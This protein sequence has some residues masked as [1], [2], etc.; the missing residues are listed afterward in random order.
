[1]GKTKLYSDA[2]D[3]V[4]F[5][6]NNK[7]KIIDLYVKEYKNIKQ[8]SKLYQCK[9]TTI[10]G[11]LKEWG[12]E[13]RKDANHRYNNL[14]QVDIDFLDNINT[15]QKAWLVGYILADGCVT[16]TGKI[17][18][19]CKD[20]DILP[21]IKNM[22]SSDVSIRKDSHNNFAM[23]ICSRKLTSRL[24]EMGITP[25][26]SYGFDFN[27]TLS[28]IPK[29]LLCHFV[30]GMFDGDGSIRYYNYEYAKG[31]QYHL[32]YTGIKEV[33]K[34]VD[35]FLSL[36]T[37]MIKEHNSEI[38]HTIRTAN[39]Q[40]IVNAY[41]ILYKNATIYSDRKFNTFQKVLKLIRQEHKDIVHGVVYNKKKKKWQAQC[42]IN[43]MHKNLGYFKNKEEA[44]LA[45]LKYEF[46]MFG[47]KAPQR[48]LFKKYN[49]K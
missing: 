17:M 47:D 46:E 25:K 48:T 49:I 36:Q 10:S 40:I 9:D 34:F 31:Y 42:N 19:G 14:K 24:C 6:N 41:N 26:K 13:I 7:Q 43:K 15:E 21:K 30:R 8:I 20:E 29:R 37:K 18:F 39:S 16:T 1:M 2:K 11:K 5:W 27:K 12:V 45:R 3:R 28:Y 44:E 4:R 32:G 22:L 23:T 35:K 38:T 33:C